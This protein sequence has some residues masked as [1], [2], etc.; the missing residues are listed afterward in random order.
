LDKFRS[1][2][3][4]EDC[5]ELACGYYD[6]PEEVCIQQVDQENIEENFLPPKHMSIRLSLS[7]ST[8]IKNCEKQIEPLNSN[9]QNTSDE[10]TSIQDKL[11]DL[12]K[13]K[14]EMEDLH[15]ATYD[16]SFTWPIKEFKEKF[17]A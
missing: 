6:Y 5:G 1:S 16:G 9:I 4:C 17:G 13:L 2:T 15:Y 11:Q 10:L 7:K 14:Q 12:L 8:K 3:I